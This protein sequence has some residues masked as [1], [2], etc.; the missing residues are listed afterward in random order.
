MKCFAD[1]LCCWIMSQMRGGH[2]GININ[3]IIDPY[4]Y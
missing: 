3:D 2:V 4:C 1:I